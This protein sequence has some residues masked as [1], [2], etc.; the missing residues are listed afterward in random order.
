MNKVTKIATKNW[1]SRSVV[2]FHASR[3]CQ[4]LDTLQFLRALSEEDDGSLIINMMHDC[5]LHGAVDDVVYYLEVGV[6]K[7]HTSGEGVHLR[8][9]S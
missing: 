1:I 5:S 2:A 8:I 6:L 3:S 4:V 9:L 7:E